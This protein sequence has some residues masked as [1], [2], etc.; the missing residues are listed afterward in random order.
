MQRTAEKYGS[1]GGVFAQLLRNAAEALGWDPDTSLDITKYDV[2]REG[3]YPP[4]LDDLDAI[5]ISGSRANAYDDTPWIVRLVEYTRMVLTEQKRVR[6]VGVCFGHQIFARALGVE[7]V[8]N[9]AW[10]ASVVPVPLNDDGKRL[11]EGIETLKIFQMHRD[12][13]S[14]LPSESGL[15]NLGATETCQIQGMYQPKRLMSVQGHPEF[16]QEIV[17]EILDVRRD[18]GVFTDEDYREFMSRVGNKQDGIVVA[19]AFLKFLKEGRE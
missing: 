14:S 5:L 6:M 12:I 16:T 9:D 2:V 13:V 18:A 10:E 15:V 4:S 11:F 8:R 7:V 17:E 1:Y 19:K 3:L